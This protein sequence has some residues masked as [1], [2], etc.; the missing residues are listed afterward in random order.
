MSNQQPTFDLRSQAWIQV[1]RLD[2][3]PDQL[4]LRQVFSRAHELQGV[5]GDLPTQAF[6][7]YRLLLAVLH[8]VLPVEHGMQ[9]KRWQALWGNGSLPHQEIEA[10]LD[11]YADRFDLV[12]PAT[13]FYQVAG[14]RTNSDAV[15][16][17]E[18]LIADVPTGHQYF[19]TRAGRGLDRVDYAEAARWVVHVQAFDPSGIKS[20]AV[21]D[22]RVKGGKGYPIGTGWAGGLGGVL[23]EGRS[24]FETLLLNLV[25]LDGDGYSTSG[26][27]DHPVWERQPQGPQVEDRQGAG[28]AGPADLFTWQCRRMRLV[29]DGSGVTGVLIAN[30]DRLTPQNK[31]VVEPMS[32]WRRSQPQEKKLGVSLVYMPRTHQPDRSVWRGLAGL[33]PQQYT[34]DSG[35]APESLPPGVM[36]WIRQLR[37]EDALDPSLPLRTRVIGMAYGS[38]NS[39]VDEVVDDAV[40]LRTAVVAEQSLRAAAIR[41]V[42]ESD[43]A[44]SALANLAANLAIAAGGDAEP[45]RTNARELGYS[46]LDSAYH[47][48]VLG[49][50]SNVQVDGHRT[51][52]QRELSSRIGRLGEGL[53][54]DAGAPAWV[55]R[56]HQGRRVD[57]GI[58]EAWFSAALRKALPMAFPARTLAS[59]DR[60]TDTT[61]GSA[62]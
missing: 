11:R 28:P 43:Q 44:V 5:T 13:P 27:D 23:I 29:H 6:A 17:L 50:D 10:Y 8:R 52:W 15:A 31:H 1:R 59:D 3:A 20:G 47:R 34:P 9:V 14:L 61:H 38:N 45:A 19:T 35:S 16:G 39:V 18:S 12:H 36:T 32:V 56:E 26:P 60:P 2:G 22:D 62:A 49:L 40:V 37:G 24:L 33:L 21:G 30:G 25:L 46:S 51:A 42:E 4:S 54:R 48:W 41:A 7:V 57:S 53:A 58:A 55:G